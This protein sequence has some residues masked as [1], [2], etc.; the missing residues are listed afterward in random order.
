MI[1]ELNQYF[2]AFYADR[3]NNDYYLYSYRLY[4]DVSYTSSSWGPTN[5]TMT[6]FSLNY[7]RNWTIGQSFNL[8]WY[9]IE[10]ESGVNLSAAQFNAEGRAYY[11]L[12]FY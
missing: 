2:V 3:G 12:V 10:P 7:T 11:Y 4:G 8:K 9:A 1:N 5:V 6:C